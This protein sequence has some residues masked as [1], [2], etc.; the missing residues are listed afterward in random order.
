MM[1]RLCNADHYQVQMVYERGNKS[2][3]FSL[4]H[5]VMKMEVS[6]NTQRELSVNFKDINTART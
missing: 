4:K 2:E 3:G 5:N 1:V 6:A